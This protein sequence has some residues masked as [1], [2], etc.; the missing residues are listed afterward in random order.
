MIISINTT[1]AFDKMQHH[2]FF[3]ETL[4]T[5]REEFPHPLK[6]IYENS[7][8][9]TILNS[10]SLEKCLF[11]LR[12]T[13]FCYKFINLRKTGFLKIVLGQLGSHMQNNEVGLIHYII[14]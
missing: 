9:N 2:F 1:K 4:N 7:I 14:Y 11:R 10:E 6:G 13:E 5:I 8:A 3:I 12:P